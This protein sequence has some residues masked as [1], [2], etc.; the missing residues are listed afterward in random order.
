VELKSRIKQFMAAHTTLTL[1][2]VSADGRP[3]AAPVFFAETADL[4]LIF[5]S[6]QKSRHS[7]NI[8]QNSR[9]AAAIYADGQSWQSIRGIQ[10]E[11]V[12][13]ALSGKAAQAAR[14]VYLAKYPFI[15]ENKL[16]AVIF[17]LVTF[18]QITPTWIRLIDNSRDFGHKEELTL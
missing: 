15:A 2:T 11:G 5:I 13:T 10:L 14:T 1:A 8:R 7:Q 17:N 4:A 12:C 3:Q 18:Y 16:L 9:V 6:E